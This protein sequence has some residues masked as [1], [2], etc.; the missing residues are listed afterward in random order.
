[1]P[2]TIAMA[3]TL[4]AGCRDGGSSSPTSPPAD[5]GHEPMPTA[6]DPAV[7]PLVAEVLGD[8]EDPGVFSGIVPG[9]ELHQHTLDLTRFPDALCNDGTA[10]ALYFRPAATKEETGRWLVVLAGGG[11]CGSGDDCAQR[12]CSV[13]TNNGAFD[14]STSYA[15]EGAKGIGILEPRPPAPGVNPYS[16]ANLVLLQYCSS[17]F[18]MGTARDV[19]LEATHP[20]SAAPVTYRIHFLG[21][22]L[23]DAMVDT[24]RRDGVP[25]LEHPTDGPLADL[26]DAVE[27]AFAGS[28]A[29]VEGVSVP[30]DRVRAK[31]DAAN[32]SGEVDVVGIID[33]A[34]S[35]SL[36]SLDYSVSKLC[37]AAVPE[38]DR[39]CSYR[40]LMEKL[41]IPIDTLYQSIGEDSCSAWHELHA[42]DTA[43]QCHDQGHVVRNHLLTPLFVRQGLIDG[44]RSSHY[45]DSSGFGLDGV[46]LTLADFADLTREQLSALSALPDTAEEAG[47][48]RAPGV[49]GPHC[50]ETDNLI[51]TA[52]TYDATLTTS[53]E[54]LRM[55]DVFVNWRDGLPDS[56]VVSADPS[57][58][59]CP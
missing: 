34:F 31:L 29:G 27:V 57:D 4:F 43:W 53:A 1:M 20:V 41:R 16:D 37:D 19:V 40:E 58:S 13:G 44:H 3:W 36:E 55:F 28:M 35:P 15:P 25:A 8:C 24:L 38:A 51:D 50:A 32:T 48:E 11:T 56:N 2:L 46:P 59:F 42:P 26:D 6:S 7:V 23:L 45:I 18:W 33:S 5:S 21:H 10:G 9:T 22:S 12:W 52:R 14:M 30:P 54:E 49:F 39:I 17:D 47:A